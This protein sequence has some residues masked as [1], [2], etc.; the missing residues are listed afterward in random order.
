MQPNQQKKRVD[1]FNAKE[2]YN[3]YLKRKKNTKSVKRLK[4]TTQEPKTIEN[5]DFV[6]IKSVIIKHPK[7]SHNLSKTI[8]QV[9]KVSQVGFGKRSNRPLY[10]KTKKK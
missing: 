2:Y 7:S 6:E 1:P 5:A 10:S 4:I 3:S 9:G 8:M